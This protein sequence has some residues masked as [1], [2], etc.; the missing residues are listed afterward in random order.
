MDTSIQ[1]TIFPRA[2][3]PF[4][5]KQ[6]IEQ[7]IEVRL[8]DKRPTRFLDQDDLE[9][10]ITALANLHSI[11]IMYEY[12]KPSLVMQQIDSTI[13]EIMTALDLEEI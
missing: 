3:K 4:T 7:E 8:N 12:R 10:I 1:P 2:P 6:R 13:S 11:K 5:L 9:Q